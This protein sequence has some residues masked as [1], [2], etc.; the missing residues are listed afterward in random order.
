MEIKSIPGIDIVKNAIDFGAIILTGESGKTYRPTMKLSAGRLCEWE[1]AWYKA[2]HGMAAQD[3]F[4]SWI[5]VKDWLKKGDMYEAGLIVGKEIDV[6]ARIAD[7]KPNPILELVMFFL[8]T[9]DE[10]T[11]T[12]D[13]EL[14]TEKLHDLRYY[15]S[16][17]LFILAGTLIPAL[18][19]DYIENKVD[20]LL[21][22]ELVKKMQIENLAKENEAN[23]SAK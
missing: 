16:D 22:M 20:I 2:K 8:N 7:R 14:I 19:R 12:I 10:D 17:G 4:K 11:A 15:D 23:E 13:E 5:E 18:P 21:I 6:T 3:V 9:A 1:A